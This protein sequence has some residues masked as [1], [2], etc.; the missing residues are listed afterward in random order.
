MRRFDAIVF[1]MDGVLI[2][3]EP[4]HFEVLHELLATEG[5]AL[6]RAEYD[7]FIGTTTEE[8]WQTLV[9]RHGL[10]RSIDDYTSRYDEMLLRVLT[11]PRD[12]SPGVVSLVPR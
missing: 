9:A 6:G 10:L 8:T 11:Q 12:A 3:S 1:D 4:L 2:D 5:Q 7:E